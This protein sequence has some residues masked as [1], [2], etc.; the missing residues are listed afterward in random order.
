MAELRVYQPLKRPV[1]RRAARHGVSEA[2]ARRGERTIHGWSTRASRDAFEG[3]AAAVP[4]SRL[5]E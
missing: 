3:A 4:P 5:Q 1:P 2:A